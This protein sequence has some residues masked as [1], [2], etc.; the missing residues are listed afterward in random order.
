MG[1]YTRDT[2]MGDL[3]KDSDAMVIIDKHIPGASKNPALKMV[4]KFSLEKMTHIPQTG[5]SSEKLDE[6]LSELNG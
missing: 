5:L 3:M 2:L 6:I 4:R 1:K